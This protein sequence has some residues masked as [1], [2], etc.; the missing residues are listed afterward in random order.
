M[1]ATGQN[2]TYTDALL[3]TFYKLKNPLGTSVEH[4]PR[5]C[6]KGRRFFGQ[7]VTRTSCFTGKTAKSRT[8]TASG[9]SEVL[10]VLGNEWES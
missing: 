5:V 8:S 3:L 9:R 1:A 6:D 7:H 2:R 4:F 10:V